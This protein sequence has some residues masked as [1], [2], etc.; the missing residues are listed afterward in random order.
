MKHWP[1]GPAQQGAH[2]LSAHLPIYPSGADHAKEKNNTHTH[3]FLFSFSFSH[4]Y[5]LFLLLLPFWHWIFLLF[6]LL[7]VSSSSFPTRQTDKKKNTTVKLLPVSTRLVKLR[8]CTQVI[9]AVY[10]FDDVWH[11]A[12]RKFHIRPAVLFLFLFFL[13]QFS[14]QLFWNN[15]VRPLHIAHTTRDKGWILAPWHSWSFQTCFRV[16]RLVAPGSPFPADYVHAPREKGARFNSNEKNENPLRRVAN[17]LWP[18]LPKKAN[19]L[20]WLYRER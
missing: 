3:T 1:Y 10:S 6:F 8:P 17:W 14:S 15:N 12:N 9:D 16:S 20:K 18:L 11:G 2:R 7:C 13:Q 19:F 5:L 4:I